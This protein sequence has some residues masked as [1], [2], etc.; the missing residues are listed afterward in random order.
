MDTVINGNDTITIELKGEARILTCFY[1]CGERD[2]PD[3]EFD[4]RPPGDAVQE[5][6]VDAHLNGERN[7]HDGTLRKSGSKS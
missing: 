5:S 7:V 2:N 6:A 3:T 4:E 1:W